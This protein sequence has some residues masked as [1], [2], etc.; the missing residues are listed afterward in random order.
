MPLENAKPGTPGFSRNIATEIRA[1]KPEKQAVA[2]AYSKGGE[3]KDAD[4]NENNHPRGEDGKFGSG[5][6]G[7][8]GPPSAQAKNA[9]AG[10]L[11]DAKKDGLSGQK[12]A[13]RLNSI[14][15]NHDDIASQQELSA[16]YWEKQGEPDTA[17]QVREGAKFQKA[18]ASELREKAKSVASSRNDAAPR[19]SRAIRHEMSIAYSKGGERKKGKNYEDASEAEYRVEFVNSVD[20]R[21]FIHVKAASV[22]DAR[23]KAKRQLGKEIYRI[24]S[25]TYAYGDSEVYT[26]DSI[27]DSADNLFAKADAASN[28]E[29]YDNEQAKL[30][31]AN[32]AKAR[33]ELEAMPGYA[34]MSEPEKTKHYRE[35]EKKY[36]GERM[37]AYPE[38]RRSADKK[39]QSRNDADKKHL[40]PNH[41]RSDGTEAVTGMANAKLDAL[42][43]DE[44]KEG[45]ISFGG[46]YRPKVGEHIDY[47]DPATGDKKYGKVTSINGNKLKVG[48]LSFTISDSSEMDAEELTGRNDAV[49]L[50]PNWGG[51]EPDFYR[52]RIPGLE[53]EKKTIE[54]YKRREIEIGGRAG[55]SAERAYKKDL[56]HLDEL[57]DYCKEQLKKS[58][59]SDADESAKE[60]EANEPWMD[61][62]ESEETKERHEGK[63]SETEREKIGRPGDEK[64]EDMPEDVFLEPG[65]RKFPVKEKKNGAWV[66]DRE[67]LLAAARRARM[68]GKD[69]LA[70]KAD[71]IREMKFEGMA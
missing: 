12:A 42:P 33:K 2:I 20:K 41:G 60:L 38:G 71:H 16:K 29:N 26:L 5:F 51:R 24:I 35:L 40:I 55:A 48:G 22:P 47:Y 14:A 36:D 68:E 69:E 62:D 52:S 13:D 30:Y 34:S 31:Q 43:R 19:A 54:G 37:K 15:N 49:V 70:E 46:K 45:H 7:G 58:G 50:P 4:W 9:V 1:G 56:D 11:R 64:R 61:A 59:R 25:V 53:R 66:Y 28:R 18:L 8:K 63:L 57:I 23:D 32:A 3:R 21:D 67:L 17:K 65:E 10:Y 39:D 44:A 6:V 27:L